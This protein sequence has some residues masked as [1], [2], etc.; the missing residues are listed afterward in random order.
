MTDTDARMGNCSRCC[1][2]TRKRKDGSCVCARYPR[3]ETVADMDEHFCGE[4]VNA[5]TV[6]RDNMKGCDWLWT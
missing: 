6:T 3:W 1:Y 4:Y 5:E 2:A